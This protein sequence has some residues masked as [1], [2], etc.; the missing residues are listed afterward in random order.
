MLLSN[1]ARRLMARALAA[2]L[3]DLPERQAGG[4]AVSS[5]PAAEDPEE[6]LRQVMVS[7][8][9]R[10]LDGDGRGAA[11]GLRKLLSLRPWAENLD[12]LRF[13]DAYNCFYEAVSD[14]GAIDPPLWSDFLSFYEE[15]LRT[16]HS[17]L[18]AGDAGH[19][20]VSR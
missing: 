4:A 12:D 7:H 19:A 16:M 10:L 3:A 14:Q 20:P 17:A 11:D 13:F 1:E 18:T 9:P 15:I 5:G 8:Y 6:I 2:R